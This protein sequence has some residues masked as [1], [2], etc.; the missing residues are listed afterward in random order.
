MKILRA[1]QRTTLAIRGQA[2]AEEVICVIHFF[3]PSSPLVL[4]LSDS[5][6]LSECVPLMKRVA[7]QELPVRLTANSAMIPLFSA[8][9][10][11]LRPRLSVNVCF[12]ARKAA[13][14]ALSLW[15]RALHLVC[16]SAPFPPVAFD[17]CNEC[18][19]RFV[20]FMPLHLVCSSPSV[21]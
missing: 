13:W 19:Q 8:R 11:G 6:N 21:D 4:C 15:R 9:L 7:N 10:T 14:R 12:A 20:V 5:S 1:S 3:S 2:M 17:A 16:Q 18:P